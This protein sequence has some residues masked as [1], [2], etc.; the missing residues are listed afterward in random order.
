[1]ATLLI[2]DKPDPERKAVAAAFQRRGGRVMRLG[3]FWDPPPLPDGPIFVYGA[4]TFCLVLAHKLGLSL[5][6]PGDDLLLA[7]PPHLLQ[8]QLRAARLDEVAEFPVFVKPQLPK[9]FRAAVYGGEAELLAECQGLHASAP[10]LLAE[11]VHFL[12]EARA[13]LL[14]GEMLDLSA[15]EGSIDL[16]AAQAVVD[17][18]L[19]TVKLPRSVVVDVGEIAGRGCAVVEF[20][21]CWGAGLNGCDADLV[22]P[23]IVAATSAAFNQ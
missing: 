23:A 5:L 7:L 9:L 17:D 19:R 10:V 6:S 20:N 1:M 16:E 2:S 13:F 4:D 11:P 14:D 3:R 15:Y 12:G 21:A 22:L 8:R 18:L